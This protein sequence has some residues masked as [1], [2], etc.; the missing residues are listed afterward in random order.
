MLTK[1]YLVRHGRTTVPDAAQR[2]PDPLS[3]LGIRQITSIAKR[4]KTLK[5]IDLLYSSEMTRAIQSGEIIAQTLGISLHH[6]P[7]LN[8]LETWTSPTKLH[9]PATSPQAYH[10]ALAVLEK[11][12]EKAVNYLEHISK[13]HA[14]KTIIVVSHGNIIR[15]IIAN[16]IHAG[17]ESMVRLNCSNASLSLLEYD[18]DATKPFFRLSLF[19]DISHLG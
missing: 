10:H 7:L 11:A 8:E 2:P 18:S 9:D 6:S 17:V 5:D 15:A 4:L 13:D 3:D 12:Q 19:N 16:A 1:L 14:G